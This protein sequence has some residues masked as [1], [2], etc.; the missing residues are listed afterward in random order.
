MNRPI[1]DYR[2]DLPIAQLITE[3]GCL[4]EKQRRTE[5]LICRYLADL[6]DRLEDEPATVMGGYTDIYHAARCC[7]GLSV[8]ATRERVRVG[9]ALRELPR[10]EQ[11]FVDGQ[12][13]Y[14][15]V[16]EVTRVATAETER[17]WFEA[18]TVLPMRVLERRVA[19]AGGHEGKNQ[20][21]GRAQASVS[22]TD[23][24]TVDVQLRMSAAAWALLERAMEGARRAAEGTN[25][26]T[27]AE[28]L[29]AVARDAL[30]RQ[31][32]HEEGEPSDPRRN[33]VLYE[34]RTCGR[35]E[36]DT[37]RGPIEVGDG[38]AAALGCGATVRDLRTEGRV[39]K[40]GGP[41][42]T[43]V[44][45]AVRLRDRDRC[46]VPGCGRRRYVNV[47]HI[48][49]QAAGGT[50]ARGNCCVLCTLCRARHNA[51]PTMASSTGGQ[52]R[53]EGDAD[54]E[55]RFYD[56]AGEPI[57]Q[58]RAWVGAPMT[59]RGSWLE[60]TLGEGDEVGDTGDQEGGDPGL[61]PE[62]AQLL[63]TMGSRGA[64]H[65]DALCQATGLGYS[66]VS[67]ALLR[68]ALVRRVKQTYQGYEAV[69]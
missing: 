67:N 17:E 8:R 30:T 62:A 44:K 27:D 11:A 52:L 5:Q 64:W 47:H 34:C 45:R 24:D 48:E 20:N 53:V 2:A 39:V 4:F 26:L 21:D 33:V 10:I 40:R 57:G 22:W 14:S 6:A 63:A 31:E 65:P 59:Q 56:E 50:H 13:G 35:T 42:P 29:E 69:R 38:A 12:L 37:G 55:L 28:A 41:L 9:R 54:G 32:Q 16:R 58:Q 7:F 66:E 68:L 15:R 46:R 18:A 19:E 23:P 1:D 25:L 36:V 43:Q 49:H 51:P 60:A 3:L 61:P